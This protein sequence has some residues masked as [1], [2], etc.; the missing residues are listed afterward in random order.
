M[1]SNSPLRLEVRAEDEHLQHGIQVAQVFESLCE[2]SYAQ[3]S[4]PFHFSHSRTEPLVLFKEPPME[5]L[6][7]SN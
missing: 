6:H 5:E 3:Q 2:S 1:G 4:P 7:H